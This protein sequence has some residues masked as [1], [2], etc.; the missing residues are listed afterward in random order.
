[1]KYC[2][3]CQSPIANSLTFCSSSCSA[4]Y[5]NRNRGPLSNETKAKIRAYALANPKGAIQSPDNRIPRSNRR[6]LLVINVCIEC[7]TEFSIKWYKRKQRFCSLV[8]SCKKNGG[9]RPGAGAA[10]SG[11][12]KNIWCDSSW[13][14]AFV[15]YCLDHGKQIERNLKSWF[16]TDNDGKI[17]KYYP[18]FLVNGEL[19]E[20]KGPKRANDQ[21]KLAVVDIPIHYVQ[22]REANAVYLNYVTTTYHVAKENIHRLYDESRYRYTHKCQYCMTEFINTKPIATYCTTRCSGMARAKINLEAHD[23]YDPSSP[24]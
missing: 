10:K 12:Y 17:R 22:G 11:W 6:D 3:N 18:D 14:L 7:Q 5:N 20:I 4:S 8:C 13:E 9:A 21:H 24:G 19:Y 15:I 2:K 23:G 16:Y 1:M